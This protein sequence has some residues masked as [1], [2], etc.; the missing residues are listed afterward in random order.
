MTGSFQ[1]DGPRSLCFVSRLPLT[2]A[3]RVPTLDSPFVHDAF[4]VRTPILA[5]PHDQ[6]AAWK[7]PA[8]LSRGAPFFETATLM[9]SPVDSA[10]VP[11]DRLR[12]GDRALALPC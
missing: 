9:E 5:S 1:G 2:C 11:P 3:R 4:T 10:K 6:I 7:C 8:G 12:S